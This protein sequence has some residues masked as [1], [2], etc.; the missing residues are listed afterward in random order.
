[1]R[2]VRQKAV[3]VLLRRTLRCRSH[4]WMGPFVGSSSVPLEKYRCDNG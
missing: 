2:N 3:M 4:M 1:M